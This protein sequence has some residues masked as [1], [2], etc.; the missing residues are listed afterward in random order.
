MKKSGKKRAFLGLPRWLA[1][2]VGV[3]LVL[4]TLSLLF[5]NFMKP[6]YIS[7]NE[8][9][10]KGSV[11]SKDGTTIGYWQ[12]GHGPG[13]VL[14]H[15]GMESAQSHIQLAEALADNYTVYLYDRRG[16]GLSGPFGEDYSMQKEMEDLDALLTKTGTRNIF[17]VST[18]GLIALE[19]TRTLSQVEKAAIY[20]PGLPLNES[21]PPLEW[22]EDF[23][24]KMEEGK[25]A[26]AL[27]F[28]MIETEMGPP[29]MLAMPNWLL[30]SMTKWQM[31]Q[32]DKYAPENYVKWKELAYTLYDDVSLFIEMRK[33]PDGKPESFKNVP[34]DILLLGGS[35]SPAFQK[36]SV[37]ALEKILP[38]VKRVEIP[39]VSH[40]GSGNKDKGGQPEKV[41]QEMLQFY[42]SP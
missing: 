3:V 34:A 41:A 30:V 40:G 35:D 39:G 8:R 29:I 16:R 5:L 27:V 15:G 23:K 1:L 24:R 19:A 33:R 31:A 20:E 2:A 21:T 17:G 6:S 11:T 7:F 10:T 14:V 13:L 22:L 36:A 28:S 25:V 42:A 26:E 18:G 37:D 9:Y 32:E 38:H 12:I 4:F